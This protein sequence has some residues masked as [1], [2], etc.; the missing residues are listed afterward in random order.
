VL[1]GELSLREL[2]ALF[3]ESELVVSNDSGPMH[4]ACLVD[5]PISACFFGDSPTPVRAASAR[6]CV[7]SH[8]S[9]IRSRCFSVYTVRT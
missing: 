6:A 7:R 1:A 4:I 5:A 8:P 9:S 3:A 2:L